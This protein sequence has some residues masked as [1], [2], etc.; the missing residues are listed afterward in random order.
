MKR[1]Q[2]LPI[3]LHVSAVKVLYECLKMTFEGETPCVCC[4]SVSIWKES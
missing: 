4:C 3:F 2:N 1:K